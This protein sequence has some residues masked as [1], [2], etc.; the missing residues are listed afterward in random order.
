MNMPLNSTTH[1]LITLGL[2][3]ALTF[4]VSV[5]CKTTA[6]STEQGV[7]SSQAGF[8][9]VPSG[10]KIADEKAGE[11]LYQAQLISDDGQAKIL[12]GSIPM[13]ASKV[14]DK[15][16]YL[17]QLHNSLVERIRGE[18]GAQPFTEESINWANGT[19]GLRTLLRGGSNDEALI[20]EGLTFLTEDHVYFIYGRFPEA[21]YQKSRQGYQ[22]VLATATPLQGGAAPQKD[23]MEVALDMI[24][25]EE[26]SEPSDDERLLE[27]ALNVFPEPGNG[28]GE[29][30]WGEARQNIQTRRGAPERQTSQMLAYQGTLEGIKGAMVYLFTYDRL[31][32]GT[33]VFGS[34]H[35]DPMAYLNEFITTDQRMS[36]LYGEPV[37]RATIWSNERYKADQGKWAEA[38]IKGDVVFGSVWQMGDVKVIH[39]LKSDGLSGVNHRIVYKNPK[40]QEDIARTIPQ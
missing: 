1:R 32:R 26:T 5:G 3:A 16:Y 17:S 15:S 11:D 34:A 27:A 28:L 30:V 22:Q 36:A 40:I 8:V 14:R 20:I 35:E 29:F 38:L 6:T 31:T 25:R 23:S 12:L 21:Q 13:N 2:A 18:S 37:Q 7:D 39:S 19:E 10:W 24:E 9:N 33:F 4:S